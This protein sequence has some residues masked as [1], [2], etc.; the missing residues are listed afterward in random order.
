MILNIFNFEITKQ[1][2][3][4]D[5]CVCV[6]FLTNIFIR[7][8]KKYRKRI[9]YVTQVFDYVIAV[10]KLLEFRFKFKIILE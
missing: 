7:I 4:N 8:R 3:Y 1:L 2:S 9:I 10:Q 6:V 5:V